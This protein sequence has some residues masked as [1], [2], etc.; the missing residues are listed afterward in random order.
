MADDTAD[1]MRKRVSGSRIGL[2]LRLEANRWVVAAIPLFSVFAFLAVVGLVRP[3]LLDAP[4]EHVGDIFET[5]V[6]AI[7]TAVTL[8]VAINQ[9]V[10]SQELGTLSDQRDRMDGA[11]AFRSAV[12]TTLDRETVPTDPAA[13][14]GLLVAESRRAGESLE[15]AIDP[16]GPDGDVHEY[17]HELIENAEAVEAR[18]DGATFGSYEVV[19]AALDFNYSRKLHDAR[20]FNAERDDDRT[21]EVA[22]SLDRLVDVLELFGPAREHVKTLYFQWELIDLSRA[23][24]YSAIPTLAV[25]LAM[26][27]YFDPDA[28]AGSVLGVESTVWLAAAAFTVGLLPFAL[29]TSYILRIATVTKRTLS[30][31]P[32]VL[33]EE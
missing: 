29:L 16:D 33:R 23:L 22:Q 31:G 3:P 5:Y 2:W 10:I 6:G 17:A 13:F 24:L 32:F 19:G 4:L 8:V 25:M 27:L 18:L 26:V 21:E 1:R 15:R 20:R 7:V 11:L 30:I 28:A 12:E 14:L 9:L